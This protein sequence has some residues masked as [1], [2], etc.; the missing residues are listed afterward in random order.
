MK[1]TIL[2]ICLSVF[3]LSLITFNAKANP[4]SATELYKAC[5]SDPFD[6][7]MIEEAARHPE[8]FPHIDSESNKRYF[9]R[10]NR[11]L[12]AA[13]VKRD[14]SQSEILAFYHKGREM[15]AAQEAEANKGGGQNFDFTYQYVFR[16]AGLNLKDADVF[17]SVLGQVD[18][19]FNEN[20][21][22]SDIKITPN[23]SNI[24]Y[25]EGAT[26]GHNG[27]YFLDD[28]F[29]NVPGVFIIYIDEDG[30][31]EV[32]IVYS[33]NASESSKS[34]LNVMA[35]QGFTDEDYAKASKFN[36]TIPST[37]GWDDFQEMT[38]GKLKLEAGRIYTL[39]LID[40]GGNANR[41]LNVMDL[42]EIH[43][44]KQ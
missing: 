19:Y 25:T 4:F 23:H 5:I 8:A 36:V 39:L 3:M 26:L 14:Y 32:S 41:N 31:Y 16:G 20:G 10:I 30:T 40:T 9:G 1:K 2:K 43:L 12:K 35:T 21:Y 42:Q 22:A 11:L 28:W 37:N 33:K 17:C 44:K 18:G 15:N 24:A 13:G 27:V 7:G 29:G 34:P 6:I 38:I